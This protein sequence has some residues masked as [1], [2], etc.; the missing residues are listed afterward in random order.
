MSA[1]RVFRHSSA[2]KMAVEVGLRGS[3]QKRPD[4]NRHRGEEDGNGRRGEGKRNGRRGAAE[5]LW[6]KRQTSTAQA[7]ARMGTARCQARGFQ[8]PSPSQPCAPPH[9]VVGTMPAGQEFKGSECVWG[10]TLHCMPPPCMPPRLLTP[11]TGDGRQLQAA[12]GSGMRKCAAHLPPRPPAPPPVPR[13]NR[14]Q[15]AAAEHLNQCVCYALHPP[16]RHMPPIAMAALPCPPPCPLHATNTASAPVR[17][18]LSLARAP[19]RS[20]QKR[21]L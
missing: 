8:V 4:E 13:K 17:Q 1:L 20:E 15:K 5:A 14:R 11:A 10:S 16:C 12:A 3:W 6:R 18:H 19:A 2:L 21:P 9:L 7:L